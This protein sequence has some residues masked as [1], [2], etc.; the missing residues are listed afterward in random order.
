MTMRCTASSMPAHRISSTIRPIRTILTPIR[1]AMTKAP[2]SR[3]KRRGGMVTVVAVLAL[4]VV[5]TGAAFAYRTYVGSPAAASRRS[6]GPTPVRPR[7]AGALRRRR[8]SC[9]TAWSRATA[10]RRSF[11]AKK[12]RST[13]TPR[14]RSA[15]GVSAAEPEWQSAVGGERGAQRSRPRQAPANGTLPNTEPRK[16]KT[17]AVHGDQP[18]GAAVPRSAPRLP[19][20]A[21]AP[22]TARR[23]HRAAAQPA[24]R[25][26]RAPMRRCRCRR[27]PQPARR[28]AATRVADTNPAQTAPAAARAAAADTWFRFPRSGTR[29]TPRPPIGRC[30]A[31]SRRCWDRIR[32]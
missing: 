13:S 18:D 27:R 4:A 10:P 14:P 16:I 19:K 21:A 28:S 7:S 9:R 17:L 6:S 15:R 2:T 12:R 26:M 20:P 24:T 25:P 23:R 11:R 5:G 29:P 30:R 3:Q 1:T 8:P 22:A 31:S 32:R